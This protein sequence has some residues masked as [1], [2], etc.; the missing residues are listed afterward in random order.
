M[1]CGREPPTFSTASHEA[2]SEQEPTIGSRRCTGATFA[3][4]RRV[5]M[6]STST[7]TEE[8]MAA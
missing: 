5:P 6:L 1:P 3:V 2:R 8:A 4:E 7:N